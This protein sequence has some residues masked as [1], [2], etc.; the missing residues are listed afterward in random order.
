M[1]TTDLSPASCLLRALVRW[2]LN[3]QSTC[4]LGFHGAPCLLPSDDL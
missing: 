4:S 1:G 3:I 2:V